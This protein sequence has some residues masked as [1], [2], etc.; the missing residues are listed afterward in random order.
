MTDQVVGT[1]PRWVAIAAVLLL[2]ANLRAAVNVIGPLLPAVRASLDLSGLEV[3]IVTALPTFCFAVIGLVAARFASRIG[4]TRAVVLSVA[5]MALGQL[6]R[7]VIPA[8][9][10]LFAGT[11]LALAAVA[12]VN[13]L[14]PALI[15][16][17]FPD[18]IPSMTA[19]YTVV[20]SATGALAS[21]ATL[22]LQDAVGGTWQIGFGMWALIAIAALVPWVV[23]ARH[24]G[25]TLHTSRA[26]YTMR[27][28]AR[29]AR[30]WV[31]ASFFGLQALQAYVVFSYYPTMLYDAGVPLH[32]GSIY[33]ALVS[34]FSMVGAVVLP[35]MLARMRRPAPLVV[36][37]GCG[38]VSGYLGTIFA[39][40]TA[41]WLWASLIGLGVASFPMG[42]FIVT[43][44]AET[45]SGVLALS[46]FMQGI[47]YL[48]AGTILVLFGALQGSSTNWT[49]ALLVLIAITVV[50]TAAAL[51]SVRTWTIEETLGRIPPG[52][53]HI[54]PPR[55]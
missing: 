6:L 34:V 15:S 39:P 13:V 47:G 33:V 54:D 42:L 2:A 51:I 37:V 14:M 19:A 45:P 3:G 27:D 7:A 17:F 53:A 32:L 43:Q 52:G 20:L 48:I 44:R 40:E 12:V 28:V 36:L 8:T 35:G 16:A 22:P 49:P 46:G 31:L 21:G 25:G 29:S 50:Q 55:R 41:P 1:P 30:A 18:R 9:A 4:V 26:A 38:F 11:A 23:I 5:C 10:A 24:P